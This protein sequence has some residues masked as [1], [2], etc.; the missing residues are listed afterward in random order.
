MRFDLHIHSN[1]SSDSGL[2]IDDILEQAIKGG[3]D[4]IAI[5]DH[6]TVEG[7]MR[8]IERAKELN[9]SLIVLPGQEI[10][11]REGHLVVLGIPENI[12]PELSYRETIE[13]AR[14]RGGLVIAPHPFKKGGIGYGAREADA[15]ETF[16]SRCI[17]G[18]NE[19]AK[20]LSIALGKPETAGSDSHIL[21]T[22]GIAYTEIDV[23]SSTGSV[24]KAI[25]EGR[26]RTEGHVA[27]VHIVFIQML[28]G[29]LSAWP[30]P[31]SKKRS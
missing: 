10:S 8:G 24:L 9:L 30:F 19:Q 5:C 12:P 31:G 4:G 18:E 17:F 20:K 27:P 6:N 26:T 22:I 7:S 25:R 13:I 28:R 23:A 29:A 21:T 16:N 11:T 2:R 15:I 1:Y 3:L 14:K